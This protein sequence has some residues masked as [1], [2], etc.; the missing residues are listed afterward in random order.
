[1]FSKCD[2][3]DEILDKTILPSAWD[4]MANRITR[5][6]SVDESLFRRKVVILLKCKKCKRVT[7]MVESN[8]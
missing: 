1:M 5:L 3:D 6:H 8:P 2:H 4:Q 7:K